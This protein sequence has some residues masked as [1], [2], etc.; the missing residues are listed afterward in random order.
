MR[1]YATRVFANAKLS[2]SAWWIPAGPAATIRCIQHFDGCTLSSRQRRARSV[3]STETALQ[4]RG[5]EAECIR[6]ARSSNRLAFEQ[7]GEGYA[8]GIVFYLRKRRTLRRGMPCL[9][10]NKCAFALYLIA[11]PAD[12]SAKREA[13]VLG[14][15]SAEVVDSLPRHSR[16]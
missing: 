16:N 5:V 15:F 14:V 11:G 9:P 13:Q 4:V 1:R 3:A 10:E 6:S 12:E 8:N 7:I 2:R